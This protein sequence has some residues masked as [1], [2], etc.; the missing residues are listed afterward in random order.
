M[1][2]LVVSQLIDGAKPKTR[3]CNRC[4]LHKDVKLFVNRAIVCNDCLTDNDH[5]RRSKARAVRK[6]SGSYQRR[7]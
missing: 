5:E 3:K 1:F 7:K 6:K 4:L 2:S